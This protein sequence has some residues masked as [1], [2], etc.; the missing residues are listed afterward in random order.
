MSPLHLAFGPHARL[1]F[2]PVPGDEIRSDVVIE[3]GPLD[4]DGEP[5]CSVEILFDVLDSPATQSK[6]AAYLEAAAKAVAA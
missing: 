3:Y 5:T 2:V 4:A 6:I 1:I